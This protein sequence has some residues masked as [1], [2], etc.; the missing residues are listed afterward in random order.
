MSIPGWRAIDTFLVYSLAGIGGLAALEA[1]GLGVGTITLFAG[2]I[3]VGLGFGL[4][5]IANNFASGLTIIFSRELRRGDII[6][7]GDT[8]GIVEQVGTR[9]TRMRTRDDIEYVVPNADLVSGKLINWTRSN[10]NV[11]VHV[12]VGVSYDASPTEVREILERVAASVPVVE[13]VPAPE[14]RF[15]EF[16]DN[17]LN[18]ELL[19]WTNVRINPPEKVIS[20]LNFAIFEALKKAGIEIPFPQRDLRIRSAEG[21][22]A[23]TKRITESR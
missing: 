8:V 20:V 16:G 3:G 22:V 7:V 1:V 17:S 19:V 2:A 15:K 10:P 21:L 5:S 13:Q 23:F 9:A 11:R 14:V 6:T 4:Q 12:P 18:F